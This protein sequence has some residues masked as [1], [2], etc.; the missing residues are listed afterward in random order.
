MRFR[1]SKILRCWVFYVTALVVCSFLSRPVSSGAM[2]SRL[3]RSAPRSTPPPQTTT[4]AVL[5]TLGHQATL[6]AQMIRHHAKIQ[7]NVLLTNI[8]YSRLSDVVHGI[9]KVGFVPGETLWL[10]GQQHQIQT[11]EDYSNFRR[12]FRSIIRF[13]YR[14]NVEFNDEAFT[15]DEGWG[16][17]LRA[18]QMLL[19]QALQQQPDGLLSPLHLHRRQ[20]IITLFLD[21]NEAIY[22]I[23]NMIEASASQKTHG[24]WFNPSEGG[25][26]LQ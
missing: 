6:L 24:E 4:Q 7:A 9:S 13:T 12:S 14:R 20:H 26:I 21:S 11:R 22:S 23:Q 10:L 15:T 3:H 18:S 1:N 8:R 25:L 16:C 17:I 19:A 5:Q 2:P